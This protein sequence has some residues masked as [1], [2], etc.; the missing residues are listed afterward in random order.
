MIV[1]EDAFRTRLRRREEHKVFEGVHGD[2]L[3]HR[4]VG[5]PLH[6]PSRD[7]TRHEHGEDAREL[8]TLVDL[9]LEVALLVEEVLE[10]EVGVVH[11]EAGGGGGDSAGGLGRRGVAA[12]RACAQRAITAA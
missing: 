5:R 7:T 3:V 1:G 9:A 2:V 11:L 4:P 6:E 12:R 10:A 8:A